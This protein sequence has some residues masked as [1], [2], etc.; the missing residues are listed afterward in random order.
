MQLIGCGQAM[1]LLRCFVVGLL[2]ASAQA[3]EL[4]ANTPA[5]F[6]RYIRATEAQQADDL[7]SDHSS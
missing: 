7:R 6:D 2:V 1:S 3:A 5:A 4:K